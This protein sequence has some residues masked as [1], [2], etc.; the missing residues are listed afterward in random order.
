[1]TTAATTPEEPRRDPRIADTLAFRLLVAA[2]RVAQPFAA[3]W[4]DRLGVS[5]T[6]WRCIMALAIEPDGSGEDVSRRMGLDKMTVS[7]ALHRLRRGGFTL[8]RP[9]GPNRNA[10]RLTERGWA[11]VDAI[12][13]AALERDRTAFEGLTAHERELVG[14]VLDRIIRD[15]T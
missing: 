4:G 9:A 6:E 15:Q 2:N 14:R 1:M 10:W 3:E 12:R 13:P 11:V 7:R 5:L 8:R